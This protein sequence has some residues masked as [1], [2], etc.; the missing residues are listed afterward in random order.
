MDNCLKQDEHV[1][2]K[3]VATAPPNGGN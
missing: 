1:G 2:N 3:I